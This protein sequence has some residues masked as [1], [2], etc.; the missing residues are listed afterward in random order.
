MKASR[1]MAIVLLLQVHVRM[2]TQQ[3]A[4][5]FEVSTRTILR[6]VESLSAAGVPVYAERG[7]HGGI[8]LDTRARLDLSRFEPQELQLLSAVGFNTEQLSQIGLGPVSAQAHHKLNAATRRLSSDAASL[9][10]VLMIDGSGWFTPPST[11]ELSTLLAA[12][13]RG[14]RVVIAYRHSGR[15]STDTYLVD[16]YGL[17]SKQAAWYLVGDVAGEPRMF[18]ATR[19]VSHEVLDEAAHV[20]PDQSLASVW[21]ELLTSFASTASVEIRA[22]LRA[23]RLDLAARILGT[24]LTDVTE[25]ADGWVTIT[26]AYPDVESVRQLLQFGDHIRVL[27]PPQAVQRIHD[28]ARHLMTEHAPGDHVAVSDRDG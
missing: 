13:R 18:N 9:A 12:A 23:T 24:R 27:D 28:L 3:L 2:T 21:S 4:D 5:R 14:R 22:R 15:A 16:P 26:V 11:L 25:P 6:D 19:I 8:V 17:V 20:R 10:D 7:R 1:L